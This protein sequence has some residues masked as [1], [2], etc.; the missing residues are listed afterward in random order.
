[1]AT[2][3]LQGGNQ[4]VYNFQYQE[5]G[6]GSHFRYVQA[7]VYLY[8]VVPGGADKQVG[9]Y[10]FPD[11]YPYRQITS[12]ANNGVDLDLTH[13]FIVSDFNKGKVYRAR[14]QIRQR[15]DDT[16]WPWS[17]KT[18]Q[19][20]TLVIPLEPFTYVKS[21]D[22]DP[23]IRSDNAG[24]EIYQT[25]VRGQSMVRPTFSSGF[26]TLMY[27]PASGSTPADLKIQEWTDEGNY[28]RDVDYVQPLTVSE[29][30]TKGHIARPSRGDSLVSFVLGEQDQFIFFKDDYTWNTGDA[31]TT[32]RWDFNKSGGSGVIWVSAGLDRRGNQ[33]GFY[34]AFIDHSS[35]FPQIQV[36]SIASDR[37]VETQ[38]PGSDSWNSTNNPDNIGL[39][40]LDGKLYVGSKIDS[41]KKLLF[42]S[43]N[44]SNAGSI[45]NHESI[46]IPTK[47]TPL[48]GIEVGAINIG[49]Y[50]STVDN[51]FKNFLR[52][53]DR[54]NNKLHLF[55]HLDQ[56]ESN[57]ITLDATELEEIKYVLR[58]DN[59]A[60]FYEYQI[61]AEGGTYGNWI[62][63]A[64]TSTFSSIR[65]LELN[66]KYFLRFRFG[67]NVQGI[68]VYS[69][70]SIERNIDTLDFRSPFG[71]RL[72]SILLNSI[73]INFTNFNE[74][75]GY[76]Y[77][78]GKSEDDLG[79]WV[80]IESSPFTVTGLEEKETY[81]VQVRAY[82]NEFDGGIYYSDT[83]NILSQQVVDTPDTP[84]NVR[85]IGVG[86]TSIRLFCD[87]VSNA[88]KYE[89]RFGI[90]SGV[91][92]EWT[93]MLYTGTTVEGFL[94]NTPY[95]F[96]IRSLKDDTAGLPSVEFTGRTA[97]TDFPT[98]KFVS[99]PERYP[100]VTR[101]NFPFTHGDWKVYSDGN[102]VL[103]NGESIY[104]L[105]ID[106]STS[107]C[108]LF[109]WDDGGVRQKFYRNPTAA[110]ESEKEEFTIEIPY[111]DPDS[112]NAYQSIAFSNIF[113]DFG[114]GFKPEDTVAG[115]D[116]GER[117]T[118]DIV[119]C[120]TEVRSDP[121][122]FPAK[123]KRAIIHGV[124]SITQW[125]NYVEDR[126]K[127]EFFSYGNDF[128]ED[129]FFD[130]PDGTKLTKNVVS[131]GNYLMVGENI[132]RYRPVDQGIINGIEVVK[133]QYV[134][135][136]KISI[137][138]LK[139]IAYGVSG[140]LV[141]YNTLLGN[142]VLES[143]FSEQKNV[144]LNR[145]AS[146]SIFGTTLRIQ[147]ISW[148]DLPP[149]NEN[150]LFKH[151][152][153]YGR[154]IMVWDGSRMFFIQHSDPFEEEIVPPPTHP[155]TEDNPI[156]N[157]NLA[158]SID[159]RPDS[160]FNFYKTRDENRPEVI[161]KTF[162]TS[163]DSNVYA[164]EIDETNQVIK[165]V[166]WDLH[167]V[168]TQLPYIK[169]PY[170]APD[171]HI[172]YI[173]ICASDNHLM[174]FQ[175][176]PPDVAVIV[177]NLSDGSV[178]RTGF[179][180]AQATYQ[181]ENFE[182]SIPDKVEGLDKTIDRLKFTAYF[183]D[184]NNFLYMI[185]GTVYGEYSYTEDGHDAATRRDPD[186]PLPR[187]I[188]SVA[189]HESMTLQTIHTIRPVR[190]RPDLLHHVVGNPPFLSA[191]Q[192]P[193]GPSPL[194]NFIEIGTLYPDYD[195]HWSAFHI[196]TPVDPIIIDFNKI[197]SG[198]MS[199]G[200]VRSAG[201]TRGYVWVYDE[202]NNKIH[203]LTKPGKFPKYRFFSIFRQW[204]EIDNGLRRKAP[205]RIGETSK[206]YWTPIG[207]DNDV[208]YTA[209][210]RVGAE[211]SSQSRSGSF[212]PFSVG[213]L[214]RGFQG[215]YPETDTGNGLFG[216]KFFIVYF[217]QLGFGGIANA[218]KE[219]PQTDGNVLEIIPGLESRIPEKT[220]DE[221]NL[222]AR[223]I[224]TK[225]RVTPEIPDPDEGNP[226]EIPN[227]PPEIPNPIT[228]PNVPQTPETDP[229]VPFVPGIPTTPDPGTG[230]VLP[231]V[232]GE[233]QYT[234]FEEFQEVFDVVDSNIP[235]SVKIV[236][237]KGLRNTISIDQVR[238]TPTLESVNVADIAD[239]VKILLKYPLSNLEEG[240]IIFL[241]RGDNDTIPLLL[242]NEYWTVQ[243]VLYVGDNEIQVAVCK[244]K[245]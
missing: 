9:F 159:I 92:G 133:N 124:V 226:I 194:T 23:T 65:N 182:L 213:V 43:F 163:N 95:Y 198:A 64:K 192:D 220:F 184:I 173:G 14:V 3:T 208:V 110:T 157:A 77:R 55:V 130:Y 6:R 149:T 134:Y 66:T 158:Y 122:L 231:S 209:Y 151:G 196:R 109:R 33:L 161:S 230:V 114:E 30:D 185:Y 152:Y 96:Q 85:A 240:D 86:R 27:K 137:S 116:A 53:Y 229:E 216:K 101:M 227:P 12:S 212:G 188:E 140:L 13:T 179:D 70:P 44:F 11:G 170:Y 29:S 40:L 54:H 127:F 99:P 175:T 57:D 172:S 139:G 32:P 67:K 18:D 47:D 178:R 193:D 243:S 129:V 160:G 210:V 108:Q 22:F 211:I 200:N 135:D 165:A 119:F 201:Y 239:T 103:F 16:F 199:G 164:I 105:M 102:F 58:D 69:E 24:Y 4:L 60:E 121:S 15:L 52:V 123:A 72:S 118:D 17:F 48:D 7:R 37:V 39:A 71:F 80:N 235:F 156:L 223:L 97:S 81:Y 219:V 98:G 36:W 236:N 91:Y 76:Q 190:T 218:T 19:D 148:Y 141:A 162:I 181:S 25:S 128:E 166:E 31:L 146:G 35:S 74:A 50:R 34:V 83:T 46:S 155:T 214:K 94:E 87:Q 63:V 100:T 177:Y 205:P 187:G 234:H 207:S 224:R 191:Y 111:R 189:F 10:T 120:W 215:Y 28:S 245:E 206:T 195:A 237:I 150:I 168:K 147:S 56:I 232:L 106:E 143:P 132:Y 228:V 186:L 89:Y 1:M 59:N 171:S 202:N 107:K 112:D 136:Y 49:Q 51:E 113:G 174:L 73:Q 197:I 45:W 176:L 61:R 5:R 93:P 38:H 84:I 153:D 75:D 41:D 115:V 183:D 90:A 222:V 125:Y 8:E 142:V 144:Y 203:Y 241:H 217:S 88:N 20:A 138:N 78:I 233:A 21:I 225:K 42:D 242:P 221:N 154:S 62:R 145:V 2:L 131:C 68:D 26:Y 104:A 244:P 79:D 167:G 169:I 82:F 180:V 126:V 204:P 117:N 238:F